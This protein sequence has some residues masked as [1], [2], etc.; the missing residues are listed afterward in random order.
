[1]RK[2]PYSDFLKSMTMFFVDSELDKKY[3]Q[4]KEQKMCLL[5]NQMSHINTRPGLVEYIKS[6][7]KA[8]DNLLVLLGVSSEFFKRIVSMFRIERGLTFQTEWAVDNIRNF[9]LTDADMM[10]KICDLFLVGNKDEHLVKKIPG[11]KLSNF[12]ITETVMKRLNDNDFLGFLINKSFD[13]QYNSEISIQNV[14][15]IDELLTTICKIQNLKLNRNTNVDPVG[16]GTREIQVNYSIVRNDKE[17]P[18]FYIKYSF[19]ITTSRGQTDFKRS[20]KDLRDFIKN[21]NIPQPAKQIVI[22]D[23]AGWVGRQSD[24]RDVWDYCDYCL[25]LESINALSEIIKN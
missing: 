10:N 22:I 5:R 6:E 14:N 4:L 25:N 3:T 1:M 24:L 16:N 7:P 20:V 17:A 21:Q 12:V 18:L 9:I 11:F 2:T 23:G 19:N 15:K 8:L 13:T